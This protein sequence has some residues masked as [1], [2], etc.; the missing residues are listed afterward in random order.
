MSETTRVLR[1]MRAQD[2]YGIELSAADRRVLE[3]IRTIREAP[4]TV[5]T[6]ELAIPLEA[7]SRTQALTF[8]HDD[9]VLEA[10]NGWFSEPL[11]LVDPTSTTSI[12]G[13]RE[14]VTNPRYRTFTD[15]LLHLGTAS[16]LHLHPSSVSYAVRDGRA[17]ATIE[18]PEL[19]LPGRACDAA[20]SSWVQALTDVHRD[21]SSEGAPSVP[22]LAGE[23]LSA[24]VRPGPGGDVVSIDLSDAYVHDF[25]IAELLRSVGAER[26]RVDLRAGNAVF[27]GSIA[28]LGDVEYEALDAH[29]AVFTAAEVS[30]ADALFHCRADDDD[31]VEL[32]IVNLRDARFASPGQHISFDETTI[33]GGCRG[34]TF[35]D[36][37]ADSARVTFN[38]ARLNDAEIDFYQAEFGA[39]SRIEF[40]ESDLRDTSLRFTD[41]EFGGS[42]EDDSASVVLYRVNAT[43]R[44]D[45]DFRR[46]GELLI[47]NSAIGGPARFANLQRVSLWGSTFSD[48][49]LSIDPAPAT[50]ARMEIARR[51]LWFLDAIESGR[52]D[53]REALATEFAMV[54]EVFNSMGEYELEDEAFVRHMRYKPQ[55]L[56]GRAAYQVLDTIGRFGTSARRTAVWL[57]L[58]WLFWVVVNVVTLALFPGQFDL[59]FSTGS[60]WADGALLAA[61]NL[62][63]N[64]SGVFPV[65]T[66]MS[67]VGLIQSISGWFFLGYFFSAFVRRTLR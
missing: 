37:H 54:K 47:E 33:A 13:M 10:L 14:L 57:I 30:F 22:V 44:L 29:R 53:R 25:C 43:G 9:Q 24:R 62:I 45:F 17:V 26:A 15:L 16:T 51:K 61:A 60:V 6:R 21:L 36:V 38:R 7:A 12:P 48:G 5:Y 1:R 64:S 58:V 66:A 52:T 3:A 35:E 8:A 65:S 4:G 27:A 28:D 18:Y 59:T 56:T 2:A 50:R 31:P 34:I 42:P 67:T 55:S 63:Q 11:V 32:P 23:A 19:Q 46:L 40:I 20:R 39:G 41:A 49:P